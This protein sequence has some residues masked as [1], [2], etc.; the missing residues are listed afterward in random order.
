ME[1]H[2]KCEPRS[3]ADNAS[4]PPRATT[5]R[6]G[7][8]FERAEAQ[9]ETQMEK[10]FFISETDGALHDTR[11]ANWASNPLRKNYRRSH[12]EIKTVSDLKATLRAGDTAWPGGYPM[13]FITNDGAAL[14]FESVRKEFRNVI[15][16]IKNQRSDGWRVCAVE[17]NYEDANLYC[18][19]SG[20]RIESAYAE[21]EA[22]KE[23]A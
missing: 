17:I 14:S 21:D 19:H 20:K 9:K 12:R 16:S 2:A 6:G 1:K 13:F 10:H 8:I 15:D 23:N 11:D 4:S 5:A 22:E 3:A 7:Y 18:D